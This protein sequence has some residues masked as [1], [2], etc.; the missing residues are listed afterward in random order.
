[1][2]LSLGE[3]SAYTVIHALVKALTRIYENPDSFR[4]DRLYDLVDTILIQLRTI[5]R[6][7]ETYE[8]FPEDA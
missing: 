1:M 3:L 8:R 4:N 2:N 7:M 5:L 6:E